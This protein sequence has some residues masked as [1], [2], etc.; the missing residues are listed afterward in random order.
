MHSP[1]LVS[2]HADRFGFIF[3]GCFSKTSAAAIIAIEVR[4]IHFEKLL[5]FERLHRMGQHE[6]LFDLL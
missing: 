2:S 4:S 3:P 5:S 6:R 1:L